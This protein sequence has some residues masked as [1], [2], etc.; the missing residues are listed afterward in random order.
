M[1]KKQKFQ[2]SLSIMIF[3]I[4][5]LV[6]WQIK[7]VKKTTA[8]E[9]QYN[10][11]VV[12]LRQM[13][14]SEMERTED[15]QN[16]IS[17]LQDENKKLVNQIAEGDGGSAAKLLKEKLDKTEA[18][19]GLTD[20]KGTG[21]IVTLKDGSLDQLPEGIPVDAGYGIVHDT[22]IQLVV[23][24][25]KAAGAEAISINDERVLAT[26]EIR[27][28]GPTV[29]INNIK[30]AAPFIIKAIGDAE[31]LENSLKL[32]GGAL[33]QMGIYGIEYSVERSDEVYINR[34][35]GVVDFKYAETV[36]PEVSR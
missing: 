33:T 9:R 16:Q 15:F 11:E 36:V 3:I 17:S 25:L 1:N 8:V 7:G 12:Q 35:T 26:T 24:E 27:C 2:I 31:T 13:Y 5:A 32:P 28:V 19:A 10:K 20:V 21:I 14:Q 29:S 4:V 18:A 34:Y 6:T 22:N 23:N 30:E